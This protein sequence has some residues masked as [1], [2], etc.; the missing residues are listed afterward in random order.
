MKKKIQLVT[1]ICK[2]HKKK[3]KFIKFTS[4]A[5]IHIIS[6]VQPYMEANPLFIYLIWKVRNKSTW[7]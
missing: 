2:K 5:W 4:L 6:S 1:E 3:K 7:P